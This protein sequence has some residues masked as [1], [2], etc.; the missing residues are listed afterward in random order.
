LTEYFDEAF[1]LEINAIAGLVSAYKSCSAEIQQQIASVIGAPPSFLDLEKFQEE[2]ELLVSK[3]TINIQKLETKLKEPSQSIELESVNSAVSSIVAL[4]AK[5]NKKISGHNRMVSNLSSEQRELK[6]QVWK[7]LL[8]VELKSD[9]NEYTTARAR[10]DNAI[11]SMEARALTFE[12]ERAKCTAKIQGLEKLTASI[13]PTI[14]EINS[15]LSSFGFQGFSLTKAGDGRSYRLV[16]EDGTDAK[17]TLSEGEMAFVTFL[18]FYH[19]LKGSDSESGLTTNRIVVFDD[20]VSSLDSDILFV[21][22]TLIKGLF[23]EVREGSGYI[24]QVFVLT[25]NVYFFKEVTFS[26]RRGNEVMNEETFWVVRRHDSLSKLKNYGSNPIKTSY[27]L[28]WTEVRDPDRSN[29][30]IQNTLRRILVGR[31]GNSDI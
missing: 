22:S 20:P 12:E 7:Y 10:L 1:E 6:A 17:E 3:S 4:I 8:E 13:Q 28:L 5:T 9:L 30:T 25:H 26:N 11:T 23:D 29:L 31:P 21:V 16:R 24:K 14:D 18:Y 27:E 2:N 15:L 19:L